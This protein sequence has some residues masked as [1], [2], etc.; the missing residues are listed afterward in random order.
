MTDIIKLLKDNRYPFGL[1]PAPVCYG[2][3]LGKEMQEKAEEIGIHG[4]FRLYCGPHRDSWGGI[5]FADDAFFKT[6]ETYRLRPEYADE[7]EIVECEIYENSNT[8]LCYDCSGEWPITDAIQC[9]NFI[10]FRFL[11]GEVRSSSIRYGG[12]FS[13]YY[14]GF[15]IKDIADRTVHHATHVLMRKNKQKT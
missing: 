7:P 8:T 10:G 3:E 5:I 14:D 4:N 11:D 2:K 9:P 13:N 1:W 6:S 12:K 15:F